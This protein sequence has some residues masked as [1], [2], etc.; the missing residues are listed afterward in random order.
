M[1]WFWIDRFTELV[2]GKHAKAIKSVALS[3]EAVD[4]YA[5]GQTFLPSTLIIEGMAQVGGL[6][7]S[8]MTDFLG[9]VVLAKVQKSVFH[10]EAYPGDTLEYQVELTDKD[11]VSG[12]VRGT[13]HINGKLQAE[14][15]LMFA[16]LQDERFDKVELFEP[17]ELCRMCR[18]LRMFEVG[19]NEDG[20]S[21]EIPQHFLDAEKAVLLRGY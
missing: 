10:F 12:F 1:R 15:D 14:I 8:Q 21:I 6:M 2:A 20:S 4:D 11:D 19:V 13:S 5:P 7:V 17:A 3:E 16:I 18:L 9:R